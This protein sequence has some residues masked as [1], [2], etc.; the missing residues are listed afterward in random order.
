[1]IRIFELF[2]KY[3]QICL[4]RFTY[5]GSNQIQQIRRILKEK[6]SELV[7]AKNTLIKN[8]IKIKSAPLDPVKTPYYE[9]L[10][11]FNQPKP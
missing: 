4:V 7:I 8:I 2:S 11:R 6:K 3:D 1:M 9:Q 10:S 5:V